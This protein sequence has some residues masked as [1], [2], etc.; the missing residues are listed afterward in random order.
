MFPIPTISLFSLGER[1]I[2]V[3]DIL[4]T[5]H[6]ITAFG[7]ILN[8]NVGLGDLVFEMGAIIVLT[9]LYFAVG[10]WF[11]TRRHMIAK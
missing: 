1:S 3:N 7:K 2:N 6:S 11:F 10:I 5:T 8:Q 9:V 4:P